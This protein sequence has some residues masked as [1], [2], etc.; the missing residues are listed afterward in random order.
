[1][2]Q[3]PVKK[4]RAKNLFRIYKNGV[5]FSSGSSKKSA[6]QTNVWPFLFCH[7]FRQPLRSSGYHHAFLGHAHFAIVHFWYSKLCISQKWTIAKLYIGLWD[8]DTMLSFETWFFCHN[9]TVCFLG[10]KFLLKWAFWYSST[11]KTLC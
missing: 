8:F 9:T 7:C 1:M 3:S 2:Y 11:R 5:F 10:H 6:S 4:R